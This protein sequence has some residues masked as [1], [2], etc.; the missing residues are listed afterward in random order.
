MNNPFHD[1]EKAIANET[2][3]PAEI[4]RALMATIYLECCE[5]CGSKL[6]SEDFMRS[7]ERMIQD[8]KLC[9]QLRSENAA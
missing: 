9:R 2:I 5:D 7:F 6:R 3:D 1:L 8:M 4:M